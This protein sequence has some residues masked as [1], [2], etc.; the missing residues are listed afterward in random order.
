MEE[1]QTA[2]KNCDCKFKNTPRSDKTIRAL[3]SRLNRIIG[4]IG[5]IKKM[6]DDDRYCDDILIQLS[7]VNRAVESI[8]YQIL[9]EHFK[10][11]V[12]EE[13]SNGNTQIVDELFKTIKNMR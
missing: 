13:I 10:T 4:Q 7:A 8:S 1:N 6:L 9:Q 11:C 3:Q 12:V 2:T 5:G